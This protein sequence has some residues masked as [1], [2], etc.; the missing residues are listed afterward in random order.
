ML[1]AKR[2]PSIDLDCRVH[3][4]NCEGISDWAGMSY[5]WT[6]VVLIELHSKEYKGTSK[7]V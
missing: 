5:R 3:S 6:P 1:Y 4:F 7:L 2:Y